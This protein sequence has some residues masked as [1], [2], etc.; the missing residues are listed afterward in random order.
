MA[1][2]GT[3]GGVPLPDGRYVLQLVGSVGEAV[4]TWPAALP[5]ANGLPAAIGVTIDRA[6]PLLAGGSLSGSRISPNGDGRYDAS[7]LTATAGAD[8]V[9]WELLARPA[10]PGS[11][12]GPVRRIEGTGSS[13]KATWNGTTDDGSRVADGTYTLEIRFF[14]AAGNAAVRAW[15]VTVDATPPVLAAAATPA[16]FSPNGDGVAETTRIRWS[17]GEA[18]TGTLRILR[19]TKVVRSWAISGTGG[20]LTWNGRDAAGR[21]VADGR[22]TLRLGAAD[23]LANAQAVTAPLV[24]DRTVGWLRWSAT[25]FHPQDGDRLAASATISIRV[26]RAATLTLRIV[27][28]A[29]VEVR[30]AWSVR[31]VTAGTATWRWDGRTGAHA[32]APPGRYVAE[33]TAVGP[34]GTTVLR[35]AIVA[36]AFRATLSTT[37]PRAGSRLS[38]TFWSVEPLAA[39]PSASFRQAGRAAVPMAVTRL[40]NGSYR[41]TVVVAAGA[42]GAAT[43]VL[44]GRDTRGGTNRSTLAVTVP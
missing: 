20:S 8:A 34:Y 38:V 30:R 28:P 3:V 13:A 21:L 44:Q 15:Q 23:A 22:L 18:A 43:V 14:D 26:A 42:P 9:R 31:K 16:A 24:V 32:W 7:T 12:G 1:W 17:S 33:L 19:G 25:G 6:A 36:D 5:T 40:A 35:S 39:R 11:G 29:G 41:A 4:S 10:A 37:A 2:D 27:D